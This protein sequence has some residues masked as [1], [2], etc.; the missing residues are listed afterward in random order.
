[1]G[2]R[3]G[4][5]SERLTPRRAIDVEDS[6]GRKDECDLVEQR[7][8]AGVGDDQLAISVIDVAGELGAAARRIDA[9]DRRARKP[10]A[11]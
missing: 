5:D 9:D 10:R 8:H 7:P 4:R 3:S 2:N 11:Q 6:L 1:M